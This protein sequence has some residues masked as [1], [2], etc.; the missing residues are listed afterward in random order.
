M[1]GKSKR[2][3]LAALLLAAVILCTACGNDGGKIGTGS[4]GQDGVP[5]ANEIPAVLN[6][7][8]YLLY[9]NIFYNKTGDQYVGQEF[10]KQGVFGVIYDAFSQRTRYY[11]WGYLDNTRC[12]DWQW[13]IKI[14]DPQNL[15]ASG[16]MV[17]VKGTFSASEDALDGYWLTNPE[18]TLQSRYTAG[19]QELDMYTL[20]D[21]LERVQMLNILYK[22]ESFEGKTFSAY[23][24]VLSASVLQDPYYDGSWQTSFT[25]KETV[26]AIGTTVLLTGTVTGGTLSADTLKVLE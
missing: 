13:E 8:E 3:L 7:A 18:I 1:N 11:V 22:P 21:T 20:S 19:G 25:A 23:G 15:P 12:C 9:Q 4:G 5:T 14:D 17:S 24:R 26:P 10:T 6:Q 16:S 2:F